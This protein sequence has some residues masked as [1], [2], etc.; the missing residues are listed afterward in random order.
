MQKSLKNKFVFIN[1]WVAKSDL[2]FHGLEFHYS[3]GLLKKY[4]FIWLQGAF[5]HASG[6]VS[7]THSLDLKVTLE[8]PGGPMNGMLLSSTLNKAEM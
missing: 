8:M 1:N 7:K 2:N 3:C 4:L 5:L 6:N